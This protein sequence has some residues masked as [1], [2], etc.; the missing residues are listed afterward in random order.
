MKISEKELSRLIKLV[1]CEQLL[2]ESISLN[3][4]LPSIV[5]MIK[6]VL[7]THSREYEVEYNR[8]IAN[9]I[10][11]VLF[12][13]L[14]KLDS[15]NIYPAT[16]FKNNGN[17]V[18]IIISGFLR[19]MGIHI[20]SLFIPFF[21]VLEKKELKRSIEY[22]F[23][24]FRPFLEA[25]YLRFKNFPQVY[26]DYASLKGMATNPNVD[27]YI[28]KTIAMNRLE[29]LDE[30]YVIQGDTGNWG[31]VGFTR[32]NALSDR[33]SLQY[34]TN[35]IYCNTMNHCGHDP[36]G[37]LFYLVID[38]R[39]VLTLTYKHSKKAIWDIRGKDDTLVFESQKPKYWP[40]LF[41]F[42]NH[43]KILS[44]ELKYSEITASRET[45]I[46]E[47]EEN[48]SKFYNKFDKSVKEIEIDIPDQIASYGD[49]Y[50]ESEG[51]G[52][53][54]DDDENN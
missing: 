19:R 25:S 34:K 48:I 50:D 53:E 24:R 21:H 28:E 27:I 15:D 10:A 12:G 41:T 36:D 9:T 4:I 2:K 54:S 14:E 5:K 17:I 32:G 45:T 8:K 51:Y 46:Q 42:I 16:S 11:E 29:E 47:I 39:P 44:I 13:Y 6:E 23:E 3:N 40:Y 22:E 26:R 20:L 37:V 7:E 31:W 38:N 33:D 43:F 52:E 35:Q 1:I 49:D 18:L 30:P